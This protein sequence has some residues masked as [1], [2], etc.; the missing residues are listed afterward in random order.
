M[1]HFYFKFL[2]TPLY[3]LYLPFAAKDP[4]R[5]IPMLMFA[6]S[7]SA[8][9]TYVLRI[10]VPAPHGGFLILPLVSN[11][12]AWVLAIFAGSL[13][14]AI[15]YGSYRVGFL[16]KQNNKLELNNSR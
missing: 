5:V 15:V 7:V 11:G 1:A 8:V 13:L 3:G 10:Q 14:G 9:I 16:R 12:I 6:S 2:F 4:L